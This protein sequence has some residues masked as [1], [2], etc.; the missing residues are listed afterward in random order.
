M[1]NSSDI[2]FLFKSMEFF[3][4]LLFYR[5]VW[6][7]LVPFDKLYTPLSVLVNNDKGGFDFSTP[8]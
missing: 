4:P 6:C 1:M 5:V 3:P 8:A 7:R 2:Q